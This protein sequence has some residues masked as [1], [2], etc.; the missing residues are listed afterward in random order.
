MTTRLPRPFQR[1]QLQTILEA[2]AGLRGVRAELLD[3]ADPARR[4]PVA[5]VHIDEAVLGRSVETLVNALFDGEPPIGVSQ[6]FL[7]RRALGLT[8]AAMRPGEERAVAARLRQL[9]GG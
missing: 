3:D 7:H 2:L 6:Q 9:L 1:G 8:A 5:V 4:Y